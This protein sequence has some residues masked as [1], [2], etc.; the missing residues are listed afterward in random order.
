MK[1]VLTVVALSVATVAF[2]QTQAPPNPPT[3][4]ECEKMADKRWDTSS[5]SCLPK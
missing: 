3:Q 5:K 1:A 2:A 4:A